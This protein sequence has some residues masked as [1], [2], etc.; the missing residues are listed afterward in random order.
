MTAPTL[1]TASIVRPVQNAQ[2]GVIVLMALLPMAPCLTAAGHAQGIPADVAPQVIDPIAVKVIAEVESRRTEAGREVVKLVPADR[3]VPGDQ[4]IYTVRVRNTGAAAVE[5]PT[6]TE[7]IPEHTRYLGG[8]AVGP[9]ATV[10]YSVD[11]GRTFDRAENLSVQGSDGH[12]RPALP[13]DITHIR[14]Q[15]KN[16][17]K[18]NSVAF[19]RFRAVVK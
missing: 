10:S 18:G 13:E 9:G 1:P 8:S 4:V 5:S 15:L 14:W 7:A 17:L 19:V 12:P 16:S 11:G 3:V 6:V 2:I